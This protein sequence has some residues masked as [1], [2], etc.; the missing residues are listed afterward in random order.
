VESRKYQVHRGLY[1][2]G[3]VML[4]LAPFGLRLFNSGV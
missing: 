1:M 2:L 3:G 4:S